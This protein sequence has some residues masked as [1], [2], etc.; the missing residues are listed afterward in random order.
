MAG[1][2]VSAIPEAASAFQQAAKVTATRFWSH[3]LRSIMAPLFKSVGAYTESEQE[4]HLQFMDEHIA[5]NLGPLPN[6]PHSPYVVPAAIVGAPFDPSINLTSFGSGK[7]RFDYTVV[8]PIER[9]KEDPFSENLAREML[10]KLASVVGAD[11]RWMD[12]LM[13]SLY[14][15]PAETDALLASMPPQLLCPPACIGMDFDGPKRTLKAYIPGIRKALATGQSS[16]ELVLEAIRGLKPLGSE[17]APAADLL[18][19]YLAN[20]KHDII[21]LLAGIDCIDP[22]RHKNARVKCYLHS[23]ANSFSVVRDVMTLG[24]RL[25]DE[26]SLKRVDILRSIW[27]LLLNEPEDTKQIDDDWSKPERIKEKL[28]TGI[29]YTVEMTPG[30]KIPE[31]KLYMPVFQ[32]TETTDITEKNFENT[33]KKLNIEWGHNGKYGEVMEAVLKRLYTDFQFLFIHRGEGR[34]HNVVFC[35]ANKAVK[36]HNFLWKGNLLFVL[37]HYFLLLSQVFYPAVVL[38]LAIGELEME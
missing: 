13:S 22:T 34:V 36:W 21:L 30:K 6:D 2:A 16:A 37:M 38:R 11:T 9:P 18:A 25:N 23:K 28:Y 3:Y 12:S 1:Q 15:S 31:T 26:A 35:E 10:H 4:S 7:V 32:Y 17:L 5:T 24:G 33:L 20:C 29:R 27:P 14:L 8:E 19:E